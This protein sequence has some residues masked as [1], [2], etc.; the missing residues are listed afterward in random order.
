MSSPFSVFRKHQ[1][2]LMAGVVI[3]AMVSFIVLGTADQFLQFNSGGDPEAQR[4]IAKWNGGEFTRQEVTRLLYNRVALNQFIVGVRRME[5]KNHGMAQFDTSAPF[6]TNNEREIVI[7]ALMVE[8][9]K[10][11]G[12]VVTDDQVMQRIKSLSGDSVTDSQLNTILREISSR[13]QQ[14]TFPQLIEAYRHEILAGQAAMTYGSPGRQYDTFASPA[15]RWDYFCRLNRRVKL[16][17]YPFPVDQ[18]LDDARI[19]REPDDSTLR[20]F[21]EE[22]KDRTHSPTSP[23]PGFRDPPGVK[24]EYL[25]AD[26][27]K[28]YN[29]AKAKITDEEI[30]QDFEQHKA[31]L[32]EVLEFSEGMDRR[33]DPLADLKEEEKKDDGKPVVKATEPDPSAYEEAVGKFAKTAPEATEP[34]FTDDEVLARNREGIVK[35]IAEERARENMNN[36]LE[37]AHKK[38]DRFSGGPY[39]K[40]AQA[41]ATAETKDGEE[42]K[43]ET[44]PPTFDLASLANPEAGLTYH[45]T[46]MMSQEE[47]ALDKYFRQT[48]VNRRWKREK[49]PQTDIEDPRMVEQG[50]ELPNYV[51]QNKSKMNPFRAED[52]I[53][54]SAEGL[55]R[56][57]YVFWKT[58][59]RKAQTPAYEDIKDRV[60]RAWKIANDT[61]KSA[62]DFAKESAKRLADEINANKT[63]LKERFGDSATVKETSEFTWYQDRIMPTGQGSMPF[64]R[65]V[66]EPTRLEEVEAGDYRFFRDVFRLSDKEAGVAMNDS[67]TIVYVVQIFD[68]ADST[69]DSLRDQ[70]V[71]SP[72]SRPLPQFGIEQGYML[73]SAYDMQRRANGWYRQLERDYGVK[74][75]ER[76][77]DE[78]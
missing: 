45:Q 18:Y 52:E 28:F 29:D 74:W 20:E 60:K 53:S 68:S 51:F 26:Y 59:T 22:H 46:T 71:R 34:R 50:I 76:E 64:I 54:G 67:G 56:N 2:G 70:F 7:T 39:H 19:P 41:N 27:L 57:Q 42:V 16:Q 33:D 15:Q 6:E 1:K 35:R 63:T 13:E 69:R 77:T 23:E 4:V 25:K 8:E 14:V 75:Q 61:G 5:A 40:W 38:M 32:R 65:N 24:L 30:R 10:K 78:N 48:F 49:N 36:A 73:A 66:P 3:M 47:L 11:L 21:Y 72:Y 44:P 31:S 9:A 12:I 37:E 55:Y 17:L 58:D 43:S 62:R